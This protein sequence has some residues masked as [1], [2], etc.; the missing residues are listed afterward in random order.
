MNTIKEEAQQELNEELRRYKIYLT[1]RILKE[2]ENSENRLE[3]MKGG[4]ER[5]EKGENPDK[6]DNDVFPHTNNAYSLNN[7]GICT[8]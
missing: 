5:I 4:I 1:K 2:I 6:V 8:T 3:I 7:V